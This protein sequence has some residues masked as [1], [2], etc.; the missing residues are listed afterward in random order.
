MQDFRFSQRCFSEFV[1]FGMYQ[2]IDCWEVHDVSKVPNT[3]IFTCQAVFAEFLTFTEK[4]VCK[5]H[6][7]CASRI[8]NFLRPP[9]DMVSKETVRTT[10]RTWT[11]SNSQLIKRWAFAAYWHR[12]GPECLVDAIVR[13]KILLL[14]IILYYFQLHL[15]DQGTG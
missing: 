13:K 9:F 5:K 7:F 15:E 11:P 10:W 3:V 2:C 6:C 4:R 8:N 1:P 12:Y 14:C